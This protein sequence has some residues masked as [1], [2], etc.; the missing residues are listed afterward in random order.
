MPDEFHFFFTGASDFV[1]DFS[2]FF[3]R[4][5]I[6]FVILSES[7]FPVR[8]AIHAERM[9]DRTVVFINLLCLPFINTVDHFFHDLTR[10]LGC[11]FWV[12]FTK[13]CLLPE[14]I[15]DLEKS[16]LGCCKNFFDKIL[17]F[18]LKNLAYLTRFQYVFYSLNQSLN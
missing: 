14:C 9:G 3:S 10:M 16:R 8:L 6:L 18:P 7:F 13:P 15:E 1:E 17:K 2:F 4:P 5:S 11:R 12:S